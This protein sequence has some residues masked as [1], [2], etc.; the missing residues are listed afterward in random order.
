[1]VL[2]ILAIF[3]PHFYHA[4]YKFLRSDAKVYSFTVFYI[5]LQ[6]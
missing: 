2:V 5:D 1:M 6:T 3:L 4:W